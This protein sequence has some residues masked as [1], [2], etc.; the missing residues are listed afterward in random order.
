MHTRDMAYRNRGPA[1]LLQPH[2]W[3]PRREGAF[4]GF[5]SEGLRHPALQPARSSANCSRVGP[6][7]EQCLA[8]PPPWGVFCPL[9]SPRTA[10]IEHTLRGHVSPRMPRVSSTLRTFPLGPREKP[11]LLIS[12]VNTSFPHQVLPF[13]G[14]LKTSLAQTIGV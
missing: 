9:V 7:Q 14:G 11:P 12:D 8:P 6:F 2:T 13:P 1:G 3:P 4:L 5:A 10:G